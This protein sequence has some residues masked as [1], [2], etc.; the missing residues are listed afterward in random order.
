MTSVQALRSAQLIPS[1][2]SA[3]HQNLKEVVASGDSA[4]SKFRDL[5]FFL[6]WRSGNKIATER[7]TRNE[8]GIFVVAGSNVSELTTQMAIPTSRAAYIR[9]AKKDVRSPP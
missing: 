9:P 5:F 3:V 8:V 2:P 6:Q 1:T 4:P 7:S